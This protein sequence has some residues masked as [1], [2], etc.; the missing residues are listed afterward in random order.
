MLTPF[1]MKSTDDYKILT[2]IELEFSVQLL[3]VLEVLVTYFLLV[4]SLA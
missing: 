1:L 2:I 4:Q 3:L